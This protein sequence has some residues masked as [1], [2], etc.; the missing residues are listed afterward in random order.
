MKVVDLQRRYSRRLEKE[1]WMGCKAMLWFKGFRG[2]EKDFL[3]HNGK[4]GCPIT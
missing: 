1:L 3:T 2:V 4:S